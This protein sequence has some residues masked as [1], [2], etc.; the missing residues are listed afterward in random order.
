[1]LTLASLIW[2]CAF[3]AQSIGM[4]YIGPFTFQAIRSF[5]GGIVL[6]PVILVMREKKKRSGQPYKMTKKQWKRQIFAG[7][8]CGIFLCVAANLQQIGI[9]YTTVGKAGFITAMYILIVPILS[10]FL[11]KKA[12]L[13]IWG[14]VVTAAVGLYLLCMTDSFSLS[15]GDFYV[16]LCALV[17]AGHILCIDY[18]ASS[19]D[20]VIL[21]CTQFFVSGLLSVIPMFMFEQPRLENIMIAWLPILYAGVC[22]SGIA[23]TLQIIGQQFSTNPTVASLLM[24]LESVFSVLAGIVL[25]QQIPTTREFFGIVLMSVAIV[26][27]QLPQRKKSPLST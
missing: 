4:E 11:G 12:P 5:L 18:F 26:V 24:S 3:V 1:M 6:I 21:S 23:Y 7:V 17:F 19:V 25:L 15:K 14:C 20:G 9:Q 22:S 10:I 8:L 2:G 27:A 16:L 13:R